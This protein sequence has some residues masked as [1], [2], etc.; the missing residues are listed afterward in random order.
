MGLFIIKSQVMR[1]SCVFFCLKL[2]ITCFDDGIG[3]NHVVKT[4]VGCSDE[5]SIINSANSVTKI[6]NL[7]LLLL[8]N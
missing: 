8:E 2:F 6:E 7:H 5:T 4:H 1:V 3:P